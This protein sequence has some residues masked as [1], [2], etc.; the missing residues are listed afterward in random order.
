MASENMH[1][2]Y[3]YLNVSSAS[4]A[5]ELGKAYR[6]WALINHP[7]KNSGHDELFKIVKGLFDERMKD[8]EKPNDQLQE[9]IDAIVF[10]ADINSTIRKMGEELQQR[11]DQVK[12]NLDQTAISSIVEK[13]ILNIQSEIDKF[14]RARHDTADQRKKVESDWED[15]AHNKLEEWVDRNGA[16]DHKL[17]A[18]NVLSELKK[19]DKFQAVL[20]ETISADDLKKHLDDYTTVLEE[21]LDSFWKEKGFTPKSKEQQAE[22]QRAEEER[23]KQEAEQLRQQEI[24][25]KFK[26]LDNSFKINVKAAFKD[27]EKSNDAQEY[28]IEIA[29][30][31]RKAMRAALSSKNKF[32]EI[33]KREGHYNESLSKLNSILTEF[34]SMK[35]AAKKNESFNESTEN[36]KNADPKHED[37]YYAFGSV[38][39]NLYNHLVEKK[40]GA[41]VLKENVNTFAKEN[42]YQISLDPE[43]KSLI[44][45]KGIDKDKDITVERH[46]VSA[47]VD[48]SNIT[49]LVA[50][51]LMSQLGLNTKTHCSFS[52]N[53]KTKNDLELELAKQLAEKGKLDHKING[54]SVTDV[55]NNV[56][57]LPE[58]FSGL[59]EEKQEA[60]TEPEQAFPRPTSKPR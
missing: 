53:D 23:L 47:K 40:N 4:S 17:G 27:F 29:D 3:T 49:P 35:L 13:G 50:I 44:F 55:L 41:D 33:E 21:K 12:S 32:Q 52:H 34:L 57:K 30:I 15:K 43:K 9:K 7:D 37:R 25:N 11:Y 8:F 46:Q 59:K 5:F 10:K 1:E 39:D 31:C 16:F 48:E 2:L 26:E 20:S 54:R 14:I 38:N 24:Q 58:G 18:I 51:Y 28:H 60:P 22:E 19:D 56:K 36:K 6:K 45:S 42:G